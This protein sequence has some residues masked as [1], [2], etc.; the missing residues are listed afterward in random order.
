M[1]KLLLV[2][3]ILVCLTAFIDAVGQSMIIP[4]LPKYKVYFNGTTMEYGICFAAY[5]TAQFFSLIVM[6]RLSDRFGRK[7]LLIASLC[8]SSFGITIFISSRSYVTSIM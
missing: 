4:I 7:P 8:G 5:A 1:N 2:S 3:I 6:G